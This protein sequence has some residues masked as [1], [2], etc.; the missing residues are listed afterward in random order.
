[1]A[2]RAFTARLTTIWSSWPGSAST[3][4]AGD[5]D[6]MRISTSSPIS[7]RRSLPT[8]FQALV[9]I[10]DAGL[11]GGR[12][13]EGQKLAGQRGAAFGGLLDVVDVLRRFGGGIN[14]VAKEFGAGIDDSENVIEVVRDAAGQ[15]ADRLHFLRL[16]KLTFG[17]LLRGDVAGNR[18]GSYDVA[19]ASR[20]GE[21]EMETF[22]WRP[23]LVTRADS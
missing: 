21:T 15:A 12:P 17:A 10:E 18:G 13:A 8:S 2:S 9:Q 3:T 7:G 20:K 11:D 19:F 22:S 16:M 23:S 4:A 6:T 1:M 5:L 14:A